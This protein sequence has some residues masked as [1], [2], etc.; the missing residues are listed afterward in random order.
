M[1]ILLGD[2]FLNKTFLY[3]RTRCQKLCFLWDLN[4]F[5]GHHVVGCDKDNSN[6]N[7]NTINVI[8]GNSNSDNNSC[9]VSYKNSNNIYCSN[10]NSYDNV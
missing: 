7:N 4:I 5:L 8:D 10:D 1:I 3:L 2:D 9:G 6:N